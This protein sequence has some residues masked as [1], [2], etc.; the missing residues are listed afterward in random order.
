MFTTTKF[1]QTRA[2][3]VTHAPEDLPQSALDPLE[4]RTLLWIFLPAALDQHEQLQNKCI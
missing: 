2:S 1:D 3:G 4:V